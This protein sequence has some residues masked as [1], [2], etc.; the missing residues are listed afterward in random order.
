[1]KVRLSLMPQLLKE[2]MEENKHNHLTALYTDNCLRRSVQKSLR[3]VEKENIFSRHYCAALGRFNIP[4]D[5]EVSRS[6]LGFE[7]Y[8]VVSIFY[9]FHC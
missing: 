8:A 9:A 4:H 6:P 7:L 2:S 1:M 5:E 3:H